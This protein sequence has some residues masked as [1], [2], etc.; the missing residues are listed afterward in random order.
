MKRCT[1][2]TCFICGF[3]RR[4]ILRAIVHKKENHG[5]IVVGESRKFT[6]SFLTTVWIPSPCVT[7]SHPSTSFFYYWH[8]HHHYHH[9]YHHHCVHHNHC[10]RCHYYHS[11][12]I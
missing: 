11:S 1:L 5:S 4:L 2:H 9:C 8:L 12:C 6:S 7:F 3:I 10:H